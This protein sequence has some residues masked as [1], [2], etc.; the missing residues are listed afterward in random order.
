[1]C[2]EFVWIFR[3]WWNR[4]VVFILSLRRLAYWLT[5]DSRW[6]EFCFSPYYC[7]GLKQRAAL[8]TCGGCLLLVFLRLFLDVQSSF[9]LLTELLSESVGLGSMC[10]QTGNDFQKAFHLTLCLDFLLLI[11]MYLKINSKDCKVARF[12]L[13]FYEGSC[14]NKC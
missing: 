12:V 3:H 5:I 13:E 1:M 11:C 7:W 10:D 2:L 6:N 8:S 9:L 4:N 14:H